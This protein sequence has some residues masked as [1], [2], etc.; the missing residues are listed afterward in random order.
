MTDSPTAGVQRT[1]RL[2]QDF[3]EVAGG[4][5]ARPVDE[6]DVG[7]VGRQQRVVGLH[8][9]DGRGGPARA[10]GRNRPSQPWGSIG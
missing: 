4:G 6:R 3:A 8:R 2:G 10:P 9:R 1:V 7:V 5:L